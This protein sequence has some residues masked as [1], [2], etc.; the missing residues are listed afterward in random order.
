LTLTKA[1]KT[2]SCPNEKLFQKVRFTKLLHY[3]VLSSSS[4]TCSQAL[5]DFSGLGKSSSLYIKDLIKPT[6]PF[7]L[8]QISTFSHPLRF[9]SSH[10]NHKMAFSMHSHSGQF[11]PGHAADSLEDVILTAIAKGMETF[12]LTEHMPRNSD[13]D[14]YPEEV[15][16]LSS[17]P[18]SQLLTLRARNPSRLSAP[19]TKHS[20]SK[21][22]A[23]VQS[24][25][26][27]STS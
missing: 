9:S 21:P 23:S 10:T 18:P 11:C 27:R 12:A 13:S 2:L 6:L 1:F 4:P 8:S 24:I 16:L 20:S 15:R 19:G 7:P 3:H 22:S 26:G 14:L 25:K 5:S 17:P